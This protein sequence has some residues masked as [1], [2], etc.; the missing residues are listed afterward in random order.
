MRWLVRLIGQLQLLWIGN[1]CQKWW[2]GG[3]PINQ[4]ESNSKHSGWDIKRQKRTVFFHEE[5]RCFH[6]PHKQVILWNRHYRK[7]SGEHHWSP[8]GPDKKHWLDHWNPWGKNCSPQAA[9][10]NSRVCWHQEHKVHQ[11]AFYAQNTQ[12]FWLYRWTNLRQLEGERMHQA[13]RQLYLC[14]SQ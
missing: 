6:N 5:V 10:V 4:G 1:A 2:G 3:S 14:K 9:P 11:R 7:S 13:V 8:R 12:I